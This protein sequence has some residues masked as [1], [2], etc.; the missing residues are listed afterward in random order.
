MIRSSQKGVAVALVLWMLAALSVLAGSMVMISRESVTATNTQLV[1]AR[2][3]YLGEGVARLAM[4][5]REKALIAQAQNGTE[6][7]AANQSTLFVSRYRFDDIAVTAT[8]YPANGFMSVANGDPVRWRDFLI[9]VGGMDAGVASSVADG[10]KEYF[11]ASLGN[12]SIV[13][14]DT[15]TFGGYRKAYSTSAH[16]DVFYVEMLLGLPEMSR[17]IYDRIK[18]SVSP[19]NV[20]GELDVGLAPPEL[21]SVFADDEPLVRSPASVTGQFCVEVLMDF[22]GAERLSQRI[23][24]ENLGAVRLVRIERPVWTRRA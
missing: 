20:V 15:S 4:H 6:R 9:G 18:R 3:F 8:V 16:A 19:F 23:W 17:D 13:A 11:Q 10:I 1:T 24:V 12:A 2:A 22:V 5:D 7:S 21:E 14:P